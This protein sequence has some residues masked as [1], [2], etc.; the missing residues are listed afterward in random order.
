MTK[1]TH[2]DRNS[3][4]TKHQWKQVIIFFSLTPVP[5]NYNNIGSSSLLSD[6]DNSFYEEEKQIIVPIYIS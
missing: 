4:N 5:C 2:N 3:I 6:E 1:E